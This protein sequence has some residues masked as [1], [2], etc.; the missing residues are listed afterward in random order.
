[1]NSKQVVKVGLATILSLWLGCTIGNTV[2]LYQGA[3]YA[4]KQAQREDY[5][6]QLRQSWS[7]FSEA[8]KA[9]LGTWEQ[10]NPFAVVRLGAGPQYLPTEEEYQDYAR[11]KFEGTRTEEFF[12]DRF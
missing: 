9:I 12:K 3:H 5:P 1:M 4:A 10:T 2:A 6:P 11:E 8:H 7:A